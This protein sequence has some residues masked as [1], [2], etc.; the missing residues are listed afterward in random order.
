MKRQFAEENSER[1]AACGVTNEA[2]QQNTACSHRTAPSKTY[3][4]PPPEVHANVH[5]WW[6]AGQGR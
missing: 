1:G 4:K 6:E 5:T 2:S 3:E